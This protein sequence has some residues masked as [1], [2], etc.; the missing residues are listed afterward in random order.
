[1]DKLNV[2]HFQEHFVI[3][4][5]VFVCF[6]LSAFLTFSSY[7]H[8]LKSESHILQHEVYCC[9]F[10]PHFPNQYNHFKVDPDSV[11]QRSTS[12]PTLPAVSTALP[13]ATFEP[14]TLQDES[15]CALKMITFKESRRFFP[16][17]FPNISHK[18]FILF[19]QN[20]SAFV[21]ITE[22]QMAAWWIW[23]EA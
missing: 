12:S 10:L 1:M 23:D 8:I 20:K 7:R 17:T 4:L 9:C 22:R 14:W 19:M 3:V 5:W 6:S 16:P 15:G 18:K 11:T 2:R 21:S 13:S